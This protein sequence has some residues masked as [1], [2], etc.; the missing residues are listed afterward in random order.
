MTVSDS[1]ERKL[2]GGLVIKRKGQGIGALRSSLERIQEIS[3]AFI[4]VTR[5]II[6]MLIYEPPL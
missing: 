6:L 2:E 4:S 1:K 5:I 3:T